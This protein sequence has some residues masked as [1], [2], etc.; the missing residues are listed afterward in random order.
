MFCPPTNY[1]VKCYDNSPNVMKKPLRISPE[2]LNSRIRWA[3]KSLLRADLSVL[4][5]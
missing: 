2:G 3:P 4:L 1:P 5:M